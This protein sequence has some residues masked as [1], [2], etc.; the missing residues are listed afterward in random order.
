MGGLV[1]S[2][3]TTADAAGGGAAV[4]TEAVVDDLE[5]AS[6]I[7]PKILTA[8]GPQNEEPTLG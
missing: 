5:R 2:P 1:R 8:R 3:S 4:E 7:Q 6:Q